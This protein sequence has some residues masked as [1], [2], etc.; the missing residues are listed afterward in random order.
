REALRKAMFES[1]M[2]TATYRV[3]NTVSMSGL[4]SKNFHFASN[5][6]TKSA[7]LTDYLNWFVV[8]N[9]LTRQ[10]SDDYLKQ[11]AGGGTSTC[12]LRT[13]FDDNACHSVFFKSPGQLWDRDHYLEIGRQAMRAL[14]DRNDSDGNRYRYD[15]L[16]QHWAD[17]LQIGPNN[18]LG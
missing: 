2:L 17:A 13:E 4:S 11:F 12:L 9:L 5:G 14:I 6:T 8:M 3:S 7:I 10:Q 1:L 18:N 16:D 15:L